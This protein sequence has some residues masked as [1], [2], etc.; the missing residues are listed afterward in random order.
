MNLGR[1]D[2]SVHSNYI[3]WVY[4]NLIYLIVSFSFL[5]CRLQDVQDVLDVFVSLTVMFLL[6]QKSLGHNESS[7][8][9]TWNCKQ[10]PNSQRTVWQYTSKAQ[11]DHILFLVISMLGSDTNEINIWTYPALFM[12][13]KIE[14]NLIAT[15]SG[16]AQ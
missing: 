5:E 9:Y 6:L 15:S 12:R 13:N 16:L 10:I 8:I 3:M 1:V 2:N 4:M 14:N 7:N 11:N